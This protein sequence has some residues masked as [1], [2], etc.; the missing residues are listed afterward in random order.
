MARLA[1][2]SG[3]ATNVVTVRG[4]MPRRLT[5]QVR[6]IVTMY[7][8]RTREGNQKKLVAKL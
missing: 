7:V 3:T 6:L 1:P 2:E 4:V 5:I 8:I